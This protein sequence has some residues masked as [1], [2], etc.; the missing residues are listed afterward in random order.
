MGYILSLRVRL[1]NSCNFMLT[2]INSENPCSGNVVNAANAC[3]RCKGANMFVQTGK[4][5]TGTYM[6]GE[7]VAKKLIDGE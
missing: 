1:Q 2:T 3:A 7:E 5:T 6:N 4:D